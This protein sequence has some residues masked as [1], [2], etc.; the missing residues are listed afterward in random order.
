M[1]FQILIL[2]FKGLIYSRFDKGCSRHWYCNRVELGIYCLFVT[3]ANHC[4]VL[5]A[6][7]SNAQSSNAFIELGITAGVQ[8]LRKVY[9]YFLYDN[10]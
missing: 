9:F 2:G 4:I 3:Q 5:F 1:R 10:V 7:I 8:F 6:Q